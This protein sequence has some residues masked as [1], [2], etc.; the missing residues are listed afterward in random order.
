MGTHQQLTSIQQPLPNGGD[1]LQRFLD[2]VTGAND[3]PILTTP[4]GRTS[5]QGIRDSTLEQQTHNKERVL[6]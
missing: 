5:Q 6:Y 1:D 3:A 4:Q 2:F